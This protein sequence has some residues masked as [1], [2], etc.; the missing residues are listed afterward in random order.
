MEKPGLIGNLVTR[1]EVRLGGVKP[2]GPAK[3][4]VL[5][6]HILPP[7]FMVDHMICRESYKY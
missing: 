4:V 3:C 6:I 7:L 5:A 2:A 1:S